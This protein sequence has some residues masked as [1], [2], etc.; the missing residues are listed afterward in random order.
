MKYSLS[1][2]ILLITT[3][4][5][6]QNMG[7]IVGKII[8]KEANDEPLAF[9]NVLIKGTTKGATTDFDGLFEIANLDNGTYT[10]IFSF[11]GYETTEIPNIVVESNKVTTINIPMSASEGVSLDEVVVT[12]LARKDS[13]TALLLDQKRAVEIKTAIGAQELARK[14]VSNAEGAVSKITGVS[15]SESSKNV[16]VRGLGDRYNSTSLNGLPLP[17]EDPEYKNIA[18]DFFTS[19]IIES[20]GINKVFGTNL[21]GDVGGANID[22]ISKEMTGDKLLSLSFS[23]GVNNNVLGANFFLPNGAN[24]IGTSKNNNNPITTLN[25]YS[26]TDGLSPNGLNNPINYGGSMK[27]GQQFLIGENGNR[28][29]LFLTLSASNDYQYR[30]GSIA[31]FNNFGDQGT[32]QNFDQSVYTT[33]QLGLLNLKYRFGNNNIALNSGLIRKVGHSVGEYIG[34][35]SRVSDNLEDEDF[36]RRQQTNKN[37]LYINQILTQFAIDEKIQLNIDTN[38][39]FIRGFE[40]DRRTNSFVRRTANNE[41]FFR[42]TAGSAGLNHRFYSQLNEDD[43]SAKA[44]ATYNF[45][46]NDEFDANNNSLTIGTDY[47]KTERTFTFR[48]F[49]FQFNGQEIVDID[50]PDLL[51]NQTNID[52]NIFEIITDR[53]RNQAALIPFSYLGNREIYA[54]YLNG[55]YNIVENLTA[56]G[57]LRLENV[58]QQVDWDTSLTSSINNPNIDNAVIDKNYLLPSLSFKYNF[59]ENSI[60][61][62]AGSRSYILPQYKEVAP[63]LYEDVNSSSFG[64]PFLNP[65]NLYNVDLKYDYFF[66][67]AELV[68]FTG[69]YKSIQDPINRIQVN[70]AGND[71]SYVNV[72]NALVA[73]I[74][75][76]FRK[77]VISKEIT[78]TRNSELQFGFNFSYL[79]SNQKLIDVDS[80]EL[81]V[82]F[83]KVEDQLEGASPILLNSDLTYNFKYNNFLLTSSIVANYFSDRIYS[84]GTAGNS[85]FVEQARVTLDFV[86]K[87]ALNKKLSITMNIRNM[88]DPKFEI[89]Q[90]VLGQDLP[91]STY[92]RGINSNVGISYSF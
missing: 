71:F 2:I 87:I 20:V 85:N 63:F 55:I 60:I 6:A 15:K 44:Y 57:G 8:D 91:V 25:Q 9:A 69:F 82:R 46:K 19:D 30:V 12:T 1:L 16:F 81:T 14:G 5:T 51:F 42:V 65:S 80:D 49:N 53:G 88:L 36:I 10:L 70:S 73:G 23:S 31:A 50:N 79:Y 35:N 39:N 83:S 3:L 38:Y 48:Q 78:E 28:L 74:E 11:L 89:T 21:Y 40:P 68:S 86:N 32:N 67:P 90:S 64:N 92:K 52:S 66:S 7:S 45:K 84:L 75:F 41:D 56:S 59:N 58:V 18:L 47:R 29:S 61:R 43:I 72:G 26:F 17:S 34:E 54:G 4:A 33:N 13:E 22:I 24:K 76:E 62:F 77:Q 37:N 27:F